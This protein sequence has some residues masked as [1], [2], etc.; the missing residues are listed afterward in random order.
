M[1]EPTMI[2]GSSE[3][4]ITVSRLDNWVSVKAPRIKPTYSVQHYDSEHE[5]WVVLWAGNN[6]EQ[7]EDALFSFSLATS[8][9]TTLLKWYGDRGVLIQSYNDAAA[10]GPGDYGP[11]GFYDL[12][13]PKMRF[14]D[15]NYIENRKKFEDGLRPTK[16]TDGCFLYFIRNK[17]NGNVK[18]GITKDPETRHRTISSFE[19]EIETVAMSRYENR[20]DARVEEVRLH[21]KYASKRKYGEWFELS[22]EDVRDIIAHKNT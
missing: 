13:F 18:I 17:Q 8:M 20:A 19:G 7:G 21:K 3:Y 5:K 16:K 15:P 4:M 11:Q 6:L 12:L 22:E 14:L 1:N 2:T 10:G 9:Y